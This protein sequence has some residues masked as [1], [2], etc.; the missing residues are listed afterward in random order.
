MYQIYHIKNTKTGYRY[1]GCSKNLKA[2]WKEHKRHL[3]EGR[4]HCIHLQRA[5]N[6]YGEIHFLFETLEEHPTENKMFQREKELISESTKTYNTAEGGLGGDTRKN[7]T[8]E[9]R[10]HY[11]DKK[12]EANRR[13][14]KDPKEREKCNAFRNLS[15]TELEERKKVW[16]EVKKGTKNGRYKYSSPVLQLDKKTGK[17]IKEWK[18]VCE[19]DYAGF[20]RRWIINCCKGKKGFKSH[21]GFV[22]KW[23]E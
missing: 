12:R 13:R 19:A 3:I 10:K 20:E 11:L 16:S 22:W 9:Q 17:L 6:K 5:W 1:I 2:R 14:F 8:E 7:F 23:K 21:K 4:H 18:D 15:E